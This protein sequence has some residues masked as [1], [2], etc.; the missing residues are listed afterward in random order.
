MASDNVCCRVFSRGFYSC[1]LTPRSNKKQRSACCWFSIVTLA[2]LL[3]LC[4]MYICLVTFNDR[5]DINWKGFA[6]L[7]LWVN[8]FM[9][10]TIISAVLTSYCI[11][12]MLFALFQ[13]AL[14]EPLDLHWLHKI[15]LFLGVLFVAM[16]V[17]GISLQWR[18]EWPTVVLSFQ[19]TAPFLQMGGVGALTMLSWMVFQS[20]HRAGR[21]VAK[22]LIIVTFAGVSIATFLSPLLIH[23][24]CLVDLA[25]LPPKPA[26]IGHRGAPM[27]APENTM[28]SFSKSVACNVTAF[29]TDVQLSK[30]RVPF[31]MHDH[32]PSGFLRRTT[33]VKEKFPE[34]D[35]NH[36]TNLT[37]EELQTLDAGDWFLKTDPFYSV[38]QLSKHDRETART[39][40]IPSLRQLLDLASQHNISIIFDLKNDNV[41]HNDT[42]NDTMDTVHT[43]LHSGFAQHLGPAL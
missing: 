4:W 38:S 19:A 28:M 22:L 8:W 43:V 33:D 29:E 5:E 2:S 3:T 39:Q 18:K 14:S 13:V 36:S 27:L 11:L 6:V 26:L 34:Q 10:L 1:N 9:V 41:P 17:T 23:S 16:G 25:E 30:D 21:L 31:L 37:W 15:L 42:N 12:L 7:K 32:G 20:F 40:K 35:F 24:P